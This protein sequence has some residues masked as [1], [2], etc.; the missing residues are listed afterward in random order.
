MAERPRWGWWQLSMEL[1]EALEDSLLWKLPELGVHRLAVCHRPEPPLGR[2]LVAW[3]P[4]AEW[5]LA[6]RQALEE[7]LQPLGAPF[8]QAMPPLRWEQ[9]ADEDWSLSWKQHWRPDP[10]GE[11]LLVLP[12]WLEVPPEAAGR[13]VIRLDPGPA[14]GTGSHP[15]TR[16]CLEGM[17]RLAAA[18]GSM[19][20]PADAPLRGLRV[21]DLGCGSGLLGLAALALGADA[22]LAVDTDA[23]A[24]AAT[25]ENS[26]L[27]GFSA[28]SVRLGS[29]ERLADLLA[30][31][32]A[33][34]LLCNILAPVIAELS[35]WFGRLLAPQGLGLLSGLL[36]S[37]AEGLIATLGEAGWRATLSACQEPWAL[38][39][40]E[41]NDSSRPEAPNQSRLHKAH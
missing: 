34:L 20:A 30:G 22:V 14:F 36:V 16:L 10:I 19:G 15:S 41:R 35:G 21:A 18:R 39:T 38:L 1:P 29:A 17:E 3:L 13:T 7:A 31:Q 40:I 5:P 6:A 4:E 23:L 28:L 25:Q 11:S 32:P 26:A 37:Q 24:V 9:V 8:D 27:N 2:E 33:D 12:A